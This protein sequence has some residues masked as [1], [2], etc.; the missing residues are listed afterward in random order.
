MDS[1]SLDIQISL[2]ES[3]HLPEYETE[4]S[5]GM[6]IRIIEDV[7]LQ[8]GERLIAKTG[9]RVAIPLGYEGQIRPRSGLA[10]KK[11]I[12]M[13]NTPGTIDSDYRGEIG[14]ILINHGTDVVKLASGERAGQLVI[15]PV[16]RAQWSVVQNL[17]D[18][19]RGE[20]GFGS[21]GTT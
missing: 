5:A 6:D 14:I 20:G 11:G 12:S 9:L 1:R 13:V 4:G 8:P 15:C 17:D 10:F 3:A 16:M 2:D 19:T 7:V 21:T 18:T